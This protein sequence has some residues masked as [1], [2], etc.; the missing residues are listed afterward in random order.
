V[1]VGGQV[2]SGIG[3]IGHITTAYQRFHMPFT[4]HVAHQE[5]RPG[6]GDVARQQ[7]AAE[8][9]GDQRYACAHQPGDGY[10]R[11]G[12]TRLLVSRRIGVRHCAPSD[13][14]TVTPV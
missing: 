4:E 13:D 10:R 2:G 7:P 9:D 11:T 3:G 1:D 12:S 6:R 8:P 5:F 14:I